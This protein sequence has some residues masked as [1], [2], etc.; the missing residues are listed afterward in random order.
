MIAPAELDHIMAVMAASFPPEF[1]EAWTRGQVE[2]ALRT[3]L[4]HAIASP[5]GFALLRVIGVEAELLLLA[6]LPEARGAGEGRGLLARATDAARTRGAHRLLLE[7][8]KGNPAEQLYR[9][10]GFT[11]LGTRRGYYRGAA[12]KRI[13]AL[14]FSR[15]LV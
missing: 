9:R 7:V 6:V 12:G 13:D 11:L 14:T 2:E 5:A 8:R 4:C 1:G 3:G 10:A 15:L